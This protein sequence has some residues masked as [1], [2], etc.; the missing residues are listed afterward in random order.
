MSVAQNAPRFTS[1]PPS[2]PV[3]PR[4]AF[5]LLELLIV[6]AILA[7]VSS[8]LLP[9][10]SRA[11][12]LGRQT[13]CR[14][15][16]RQLTTAQTLYAQDNDEQIARES[17]EPNGVTLN[18]WGQVSHP[19][20]RDVWYNALLRTMGM[21]EAQEFEPPA[22]R[23]DFYGPN[24]IIHCPTARFPNRAS[25]DEVA[26]FSIAMNSKLILRPAS[27][28]KLSTILYPSETVM[29]LDNRLPDE[30]AIDSEQTRIALGQPSAYASRFVARHQGNGQLA[31]SDGHIETSSGRIVVTNGLAPFPPVGITWTANPSRNPNLE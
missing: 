23:Q 30:P 5:T 8:M 1:L 6:I 2:I 14:N 28:I 29:F 25:A 7:V 26:F 13:V 3:A 22:A 31:F 4:L 27:T 10:L 11:K 19:L 16:L 20:G 24:Q 15:N 18:L 17:F 21:R 9:A 12:A